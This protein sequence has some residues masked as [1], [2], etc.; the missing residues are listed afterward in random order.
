MQITDSRPECSPDRITPPLT[1]VARPSPQFSTRGSLR[2]L[3][4]ACRTISLALVIALAGTGFV[5]G[6]AEQEPK[7]RSVAVTVGGVPF[8]LDEFEKAFWEHTVEEGVPAD[9]SSLR[10]FVPAYIDQALLEVLAAAEVQ[11]LPPASAQRLADHRERAMIEALHRKE[12]REAFDASRQDLESAYE[13]LGRRLRLGY[14]FVHDQEAAEGIIS[15][16]KQGAA[17]AAVAR[18]QSQDERSRESGGDLGWLDYYDL[19]LG[20]RDKVF[21][22]P[23]DGLGGPYPWSQGYQIFKVMDE[24]PNPARGAL[25]VERV[26]LEA[27]LSAVAVR[28][29]R[30]EFE[31]N[32][33]RKY[34]YTVDPVE[35]TW[36]TAFLRDRTSTLK[37]YGEPDSSD[38]DDLSEAVSRVPWTSNPIPEADSDR[39]LATMNVPDGVIHPVHVIDQL[40]TLPAIGWPRFEDNRDVEKVLREIALIWLQPRDAMAQGLDRDPEVVREVGEREKEIRTRVFYRTEVRSRAIPSDDE[41]R[42]TYEANLDQYYMPEQRRFV[43]MGSSSRE[44]A[45]KAAQLMRQ[46][47]SVEQIRARLSPEDDS[48]EIIGGRGTP[49]MAYGSSPMLDD[50]LFSLPPGGV[51]E[52]IPVGQSFTVARVQEIVPEGTQPYEEVFRDIR[53]EIIETRADSLLQILLDSRRDEFPVEINWDVVM[54]ARL[55]APE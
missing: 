17:F 4:S 49:L 3:P 44:N 48:I 1:V 16:L 2:V 19:P 30:T 35:V 33:L 36:M 9:T 43:A 50:V 25:D 13:R 47:M 8:H 5:G 52:P 32:L 41:V 42:A 38:D 14:I 55:E 29:A 40:M 20:V 10:A 23:K 27:E 22:L 28:E 7:G 54:Q 26:R 34:G 45:A 12:F 18:G 31:E 24:K 21:S 51:S 46:G 6:C 37:R 53:R 15:R 39:V 11:E